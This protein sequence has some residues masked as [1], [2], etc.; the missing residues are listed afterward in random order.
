MAQI[1]IR[2]GD[3]DYKSLRS[4]AEKK[5]MTVSDYMRSLVGKEQGD[6]KIVELEQ[7]LSHRIDNLVAELAGIINDL[8]AKEREARLAAKKAQQGQ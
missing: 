8:R 4:A 5:G 7:R 1:N 6:E 2:M 3:A